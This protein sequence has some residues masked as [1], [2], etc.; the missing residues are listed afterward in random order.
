MDVTNM[1]SKTP[2]LLHKVQQDFTSLTFTLDET[3]RWAPSRKTVYY[4]HDVDVRPHNLL[5]ELAHAVLDHHSY[6]Q[7]IELIQI[8]REA[9]E[10]AQNVLGPKYSVIID[11]DT[12]QE[13]LETYRDWLHKRSLCPDCE[14]NGIHTKTGT[15]KCF[16]CGC[17][18]RANDARICELRRF[19]V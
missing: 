19:K 13:A 3:F 14:N 15:Y 6:T 2:M 9:W 16:A 7:D 12:I 8:E 17:Q 11:E 4:T 18:W 1:P 5:H 10:Y